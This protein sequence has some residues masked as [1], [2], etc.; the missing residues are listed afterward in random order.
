MGMLLDIN[1]YAFGKGVSMADFRYE[2]IKQLLR[3]DI[4]CHRAK[5]ERLPSLIELA[6]HYQAS[7]NTIQR[8]VDELAKEGFLTKRRGSGIYVAAARSKHLRIGFVY[9]WTLQELHAFQWHHAL[10]LHVEQEIARLGHELVVLCNVGKDTGEPAPPGF[11]QSLLSL[12][13]VLFFNMRYHRV[14]GE[15]LERGIPALSLHQVGPIHNMS[16]IEADGAGGVYLAARHLIAFGHRRIAFVTDRYRRQGQ[17]HLLFEARE[18][19]WRDALLEAGLPSDDSLI[20]QSPRADWDAECFADFHAMA[21]APDPVTAFICI[22]DISASYLYKAINALG[23]RVPHDISV[24]GCE[25]T[26][27]SD[28]L[29]PRITSVDI[30]QDQ[31]ARHAVDRLVATIQG[32]SDDMQTVIFKTRLIIKESTASCQRTERMEPPK[33]SEE[34]PNLEEGLLSSGR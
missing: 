19:G 6:A 30:P 32:G 28:L 26:T 33:G 9:P 16:R 24:V 8:A 31:I 2:K 3:D 21:Q 12:D 17:R 4:L 18:E 10:I 23:L 29:T 11:A 1:G 34:D 27:L 25:N 5:G 7:R 20:L 13:G 15:T 22:N 14:I